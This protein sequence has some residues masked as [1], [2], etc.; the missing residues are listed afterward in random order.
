MRPLR[1]EERQCN[2]WTI[3]SEKRHLISKLPNYL[4]VS[5]KRFQY[6]VADKKN[7]KIMSKINV[8]E[9]L[10]VQEDRFD[11]YSIIIHR[12]CLS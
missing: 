12:V 7:H 3:Q 11:L 4:M 9:S 10:A 8:G 6:S 1:L 5:I 2:Y